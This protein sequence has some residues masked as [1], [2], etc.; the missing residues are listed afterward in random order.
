MPVLLDLNHICSNFHT[1]EFLKMD[2]AIF[3]KG[4][5]GFVK[6]MENFKANNKTISILFTGE[7]TDGVSWCSDC[8]DG[9]PIFKKTFISL[10]IKYYFS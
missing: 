1:I 6:F 3:V 10:L 5:D 9:N 4:Y 8:N 2:S 7:K